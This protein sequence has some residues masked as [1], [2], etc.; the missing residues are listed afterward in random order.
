MRSGGKIKNLRYFLILNRRLEGDR[1][2]WDE[3]GDLKQGLKKNYKIIQ[4]Y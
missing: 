3:I 1:M 2:G 4:K